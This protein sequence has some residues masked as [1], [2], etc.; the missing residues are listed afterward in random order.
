MADFDLLDE[1]DALPP[2]KTMNFDIIWE[3]WE[4]RRYHYNLIVGGIGLITASSLYFQS[5]GFNLEIGPII[6]W[7]IAA[8]IYAII[9]NVCYVAGWLLDTFCFIFTKHAIPHLIKNTLW[10]LGT[11]I[12]V[13]PFLI[14]FYRLIL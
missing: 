1:Q 12:S 6:F 9:A 7:V 2:Q 3:W 8:A 11:F 14:I 5:A 10:L 13:L 4:D